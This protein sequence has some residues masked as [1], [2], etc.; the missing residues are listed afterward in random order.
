MSVEQ[1]LRGAALD[2]CE[3]ELWSARLLHMD[4]QNRHH[5]CEGGCKTHTRRKYRLLYT[6][7]AGGAGAREWINMSN[8]QT[9]RRIPFETGSINL[10]SVLALHRQHPLPTLDGTRQM[11]MLMFLSLPVFQ[12]PAPW[13][14]VWR[15]GELFPIDVGDGLTLE[16][17]PKPEGK[18]Q[19]EAFAQKYIGSLNDCYRMSLRTL[20]GESVM[21]G[22]ERYE[23][24]MSSFFAGV[25][26]AERPYPCLTGCNSSFRGCAHIKPADV[27][28]GYFRRNVH[29]V[30]HA[31]RFALYHPPAPPPP[32]P[33]P[34]ADATDADAAAAAAATAVDAAAA[35]ERLRLAEVP[36]HLQRAA[37]DRRRAKLA[38]A[39][40]KVERASPPPP[41]PPYVA[42]PPAV[43]GDGSG[44]DP[45]AAAVAQP[46]ADGGGGGGGSAA[47]AAAAARAATSSAPASRS[48]GCPPPTS[49]RR[50]RR[51]SLRAAAAAS[52]R[53][54][55]R[56][57]RKLAWVLTAVQLGLIGWV[58][59]LL[60]E[61]YPSGRRMLRALRYSVSRSS[62][63][64]ILT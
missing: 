9:G 62:R 14:V 40:E 18:T 58:A 47:A 26:P 15:G 64:G 17:R 21:H 3:Y 11:L 50:R 56:P 53:A 19:W 13:N 34:P 41:P 2:G 23:A 24:C 57:T 39:A 44:G 25:C 49:A 46:S 27:V 60:C 45:F 59:A 8:T 61:R 33:P 54:A 36:F 48:S 30:K 16:E 63:G 55:P 28:P 52:Q 29:V 7:A 31:A 5:Y 1:L 42:R 32:P 43:V 51:S 4:R 38:A 20:C 22:E 10:H 35:E 12:D 37:A 6:E